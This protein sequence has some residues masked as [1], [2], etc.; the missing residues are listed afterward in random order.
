MTGA[1]ATVI[2]IATIASVLTD[3]VV[4]QRKLDASAIRF[5]EPAAALTVV[6]NRDE[7][8]T[9][10]LN[11][12]DNAV[13]YSDGDPRISIRLKRS[14]LGDRADVFIK[15]AGIGIPQHELKRV[16][17]RFYRGET[18][19]SKAT[20]GTGL[21]LFIV[22]S[23]IEKHGGRVRAQSRGPGQGSTFL[24]RLPIDRVS[25]GSG[26]DRVLSNDEC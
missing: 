14:G 23:I 7:L 19:G 12:L 11:L 4:A 5:S 20:R 15:D 8:Q 25:T 1:S 3:I 24:V 17:K 18:R 13:K 16:F 21:G 10:F 9:A 6:G 2:T 26:S 22:R